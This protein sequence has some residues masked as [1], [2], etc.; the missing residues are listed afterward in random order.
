MSRYCTNTP[1]TAYGGA[2]CCVALNSLLTV[3]ASSP[4]NFIIE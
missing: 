1:G 2:A 3:H 4:Y